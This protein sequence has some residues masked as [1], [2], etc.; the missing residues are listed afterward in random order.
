MTFSMNG[1]KLIFSF[2]II[3]GNNFKTLHIPRHKWDIFFFFSCKAGQ[4]MKRYVHTD[5]N[6]L[7][8]FNWIYEVN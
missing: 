5:S 4:N 8:I 6:F 1:T 7:P 3:D 2:N